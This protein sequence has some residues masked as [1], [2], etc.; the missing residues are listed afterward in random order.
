M[1][2]K[3]LNATD[4]PANPTAEAYSAALLPLISRLRTMP[5]FGD[6]W[7]T[8]RWLITRL[9]PATE[10]ADDHLASDVAARLLALALNHDAWTRWCAAAF[11]LLHSPLGSRGGVH[12]ALNEPGL[13]A[14][15]EVLVDAIR[16]TQARRSG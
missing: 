11:R 16:Q 7:H 3:I 2:E 8:H 5:D 4:Q 9:H 15:T 1:V 12:S 10:A 6:K 13:I 14:I